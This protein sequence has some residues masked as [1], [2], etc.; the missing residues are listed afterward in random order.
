MIP[1]WIGPDIRNSVLAH[2]LHVLLLGGVVVCGWQ[3]VTALVKKPTSVVRALRKAAYGA[4]LA[5]LFMLLT[6]PNPIPYLRAAAGIA[7]LLI[8]FKVWDRISAPGKKDELITGGPAS[9][10]G[11]E[12]ESIPASI[13]YRRD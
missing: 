10:I 4:W 5:V 11:R 6:Q 1:D 3:T 13:G 2:I 7:A 8:V 12:G 9:A